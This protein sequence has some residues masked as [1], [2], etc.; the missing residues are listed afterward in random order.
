MDGSLVQAVDLL[1]DTLKHSPEWEAWQT[2]REVVAKDRDLTQ[3][4]ARLQDLTGRWQ[5]ARVTGHG[6]GGPDANEL[7]T[8][9]EKLKKH[10]LL[11]RQEEAGQRLV[12]LLQE[13]NDLM[14]SMLGVDFAVNAARRTGGCCG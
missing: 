10:P 13:A 5:V 6:F 4:R 9:K 12:A 1:A 3:L 14:T 2:T 7:A 11:L 8:I